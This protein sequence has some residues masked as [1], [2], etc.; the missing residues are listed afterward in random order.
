MAPFYAAE[1]SHCAIYTLTKPLSRCQ[2][3]TST[4]I[5]LPHLMVV[6]TALS[7]AVADACCPAGAV[8]SCISGTAV[9]RYIT[10]HCKH[11]CQFNRPCALLEV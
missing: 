6:F 8:T 7:V 4:I 5:F 2:V 10:Q 9:Q 11:T 3:I 1:V